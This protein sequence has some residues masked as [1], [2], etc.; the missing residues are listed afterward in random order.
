MA[1]SFH[2]F[3]RF[4]FTCTSHLKKDCQ[5]VTWSAFPI[6]LTVIIGLFFFRLFYYLSTFTD[7]N[8]ISFFPI[9]A[10]TASV[11]PFQ[12]TWTSTTRRRRQTDETFP[13]PSRR[14]SESLCHRWGSQRRRTITVIAACNVTDRQARWR[15]CKGRQLVERRRCEG[16][17][18]PWQRTR[19]LRKAP[20]R[21]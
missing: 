16:L 11:I 13:T 9:F 4:N 21:R 3:V 7:V 1:T 14:L 17:P 12:L 18:N 19:L 2:I 15:G 20:R 5:N 8:D 6:Y 10:T